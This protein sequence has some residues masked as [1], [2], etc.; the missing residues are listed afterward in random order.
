M[1][2]PGPLLAAAAHHA[3]TVA[4]WSRSAEEAERWVS[5]AEHPFPVSVVETWWAETDV[6]PWLLLD[7]DRVPAGYGEVWDDADEDEVEL[8]RLIVDP[9]RRRQ[10]FG[11]LLVDQL[12]T[13]AGR[14]GRTDCFLRAAPDNPAALALYRSAGFGDVDPAQAA[15]WNRQQPRDY[16]WLQQSLSAG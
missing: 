3:E 12:L 8:A 14:S 11:R 15:E 1:K 4:G 10:G 2:A 5:K 16:I 13:L 7:S 9:H 6:Q